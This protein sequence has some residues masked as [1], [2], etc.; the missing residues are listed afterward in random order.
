[1]DFFEKGFRAEPRSKATEYQTVKAQPQR[2][3]VEK[4]E[5]LSET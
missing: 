2:I 1:M 4:P 5:L 3:F